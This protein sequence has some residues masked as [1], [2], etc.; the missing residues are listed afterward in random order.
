MK[1]PNK[2]LRNLKPY[3]LASHKIWSV[4]PEKR[5]EIL[6]LDWNEAS[7]PPS[8]KVRERILKILEEPCFFNLYPTTYNEE[9]HQLLSD[10]VGLPKDNIQYFGSSD[11]LHEYICKV[12]ISVGDPVI[13]EELLQTNEGRIPN[14]YKLHYMNGKLQFVYVSVDREGC[15]ARNI[16]DANWEPLLFSWNGTEKNAKNRRG[17]EI[18][19]PVSFEQMKIIGEKIAQNFKYVRVDYYDVDGKLYFGEITLHHGGGFDVFVPESYDLFYGQ[20][21]HL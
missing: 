15:N 21:L 8:P 5:S 16:Y 4:T 17:T 11:A 7:I 12:F 6:K 18:D 1:F 19:P 14:D 13:V 2:Y 10:Y 9:L 20:Q 3:K